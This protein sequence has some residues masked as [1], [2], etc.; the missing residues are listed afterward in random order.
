MW[1]EM[2]VMVWKLEVKKFQRVS[3][4]V[5]FVHPTTYQP[6]LYK[7]NGFNSLIGSHYDEY[8]VKYGIM[9][10][11]ITQQDFD[12]PQGD[13]LLFIGTHFSGWVK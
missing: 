5:L 11:N 1:Q 13:A 12:I 4:Y 9:S 10:L 7:M 8:I 3:K 6:L 2:E